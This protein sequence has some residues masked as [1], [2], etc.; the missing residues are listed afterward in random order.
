MEPHNSFVLTN[1]LSV[2]W[3][4]DFEPHSYQP[5]YMVPGVEEVHKTAAMIM[6][7]EPNTANWSIK[8]RVFRNRFLMDA[9]MH[10]LFPKHAVQMPG[11]TVNQFYTAV[12]TSA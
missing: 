3:T 6:H 8:C 9:H 2:L 1:K 7:W 12:I 10:L 4:W 5:I 11:L